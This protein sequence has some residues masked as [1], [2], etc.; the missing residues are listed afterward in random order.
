[1]KFKAVI[2]DLFG[3]LV[4]N[5]STAEHKS[6]LS[7]M[8]EILGVPGAP[9]TSMWFDTFQMRCVGEFKT[10]VDNILY[11]CK[12]LDTIPDREMLNKA[13][14]IRFNYTR[15]SLIPKRNAI[16]T[17]KIIKTSAH[18]L[19]LI[20]DCSSEV[21]AIWQETDFKGLFDITLFS[22][23]EGIKKPDKEIYLR[24][25]RRLGILPNQCLYVGDGSSNELDGSQAVGMFPV[26]IYD[27]DESDAHRI[28][29]QSW[30]G[31][32]ISNIQKVLS[33]L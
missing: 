17:L 9:F 8:S 25:C 12:K 31:E 7:K 32:Q 11:I 16:N 15:N 4:D 2:F 24:A 20:S 26:L 23:E 28:D 1:M 27:D 14:E 6:V 13:A 10:T 3:T 18:K 33:Y 22:C 21:P 19:G 5:F 29:A 30:T